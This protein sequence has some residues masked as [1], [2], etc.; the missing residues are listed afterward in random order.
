MVVVSPDQPALDRVI[1]IKVA[2]SDS[3]QL[4][5]ST[6]C[7]LFNIVVVVI[8]IFDKYFVVRPV[9]LSFTIKDI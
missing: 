2:L 1:D 3:L 6:A 4:Q 8:P 5:Q 9:D 7:N